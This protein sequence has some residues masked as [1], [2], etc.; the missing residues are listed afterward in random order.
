MKGLVGWSIGLVLV[1]HEQRLSL[2]KDK[3]EPKWS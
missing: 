1:W 3:F 2:A